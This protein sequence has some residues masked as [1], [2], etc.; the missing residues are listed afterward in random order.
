ML[1]IQ[2]SSNGQVVFT[3]SGRI[4]EEHT[5]ELDQ[6][7]RSEPNGRSIVLD[8]RDLTLVGQDAIAFLERC[9]SDGVT[10]MNCPGYIREWITRQR[11]EG[12]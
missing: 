11:S 8:L 6:L 7:I 10:L 1:R 4:D 2:R 9:E 3:L 12:N 5:A